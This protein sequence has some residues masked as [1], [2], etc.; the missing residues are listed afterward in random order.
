MKDI[1]MQRINLMELYKAVVEKEKAGYECV[2]PITPIPQHTKNWG[3]PKHHGK[4]RKGD[5]KG[6]EER[7]KYIVKM[8]K[9]EV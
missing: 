4:Y 5:F 2:H 9:V 6:T 3:K 7:V 1:V 8:R